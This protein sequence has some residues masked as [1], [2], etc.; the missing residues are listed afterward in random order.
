MQKADIEKAYNDQKHFWALV[1]KHTPRNLCTDSI[2]AKQWYDYHKELLNPSIEPEGGESSNFS[3]FVAT[4]IVC[5]DN[6]CMNCDSNENNH[7]DELLKQLNRPIHESE[8]REQIDKAKREKSP[9]EDGILNE[10]VKLAKEKL[11]PILKMLFN[12]IFHYSIFPSSW[13][14]G[15]IIS[16]FKKGR[17]NNPAN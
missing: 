13:R 10:L 1:K 15:I 9:G 4:Y 3:K 12:T 17:R 16:I 7:H 14:L 6:T 2:S 5:H 8:I 11:I